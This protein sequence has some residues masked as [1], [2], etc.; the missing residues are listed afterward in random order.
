M[1][2]DT[3]LGKVQTLINKH[4]MFPPH[5]HVLVALSGGADSVT[6]LQV[7]CSLQKELSIDRLAAVHIHHGLRGE[8]ADRDE[9]LVHA[10]C[11]RLGVSLFVHHADVANVAKTQRLGLEEAG[12]AVR[13]AVFEELALAEGF[14]HVATAHTASDNIETVLM[15]VARGTGIGGLAGIPAVRGNVVR[16]LL[17]CTREEIECFCDRHNLMY[18]VD[19]TNA[20]TAFARNR[21]R[22]CIVPELYRLNPRIHEAVTRLSVMAR[23]DEDYWQGVVSDAVKAAEVSRGVYDAAMLHA[24][25]PALKRRVIRRLLVS[26]DGVCEEHH[27]RQIME[28]LSSEGAVTL[29]PNKTVTIK[30]GYLTVDAES[31]ASPDE[32]LLKAGEIYHFGHVAYRAE[33]WDRN[34][35]EN[36]RKIHKILLQYTCDYDKIK[37][38]AYVRSRREGDA[39]SPYGRGGKRSLKKWFNAE[40]LP[41]VYRNCIPVVADEEGIALVVGLGCDARTAIDDA[42]KQILVFYII[43]EDQTYA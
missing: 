30:Q 34:T 20:D 7:L 11:D 2:D 3:V 39:C 37:G 1:M 21:V 24:L 5:A 28:Q 12:R 33:V 18:A 29:G 40:K 16:P 23:E 19:S 36:H 8:E 22:H 25:P 43:E 42:T 14:T 27:V 31:T 9:Q 17:T 26:L 6:L 35:F 13:Y 41:A 38:T 10:L 32:R 4:A 15:H